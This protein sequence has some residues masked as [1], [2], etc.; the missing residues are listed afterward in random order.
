M[1]LERTTRA[2][3][4]G[5][6]Q[7]LK[8]SPLTVRQHGSTRHGLSLSDRPGSIRRH[9]LGEH[10]RSFTIASF[11]SPHAPYHVPQKFLDLY[12]RDELPLPALTPLEQENQEAI[13]LSDDQLREIK[14]GY[15]AAI[16]EVDFHVGR[17]LTTLNEL[18]RT[19]RTLI[20]FV[21]DHGEWLGDHLRL[22]KG[23]PGD[24]AVSRVPLI[25]ALPGG[26]SGHHESQI[27][28][29]VD[30]A[31][32]ILEALGVP[33]PTDMQGRSLL[34][35]LQGKPFDGTDIAVTEH[36]GWRSIRTPHHRYVISA[37]GT[38][39]LWEVSHDPSSETEVTVDRDEILA[40]HRKLFITHLLNS[41]RTLP[42]QWAY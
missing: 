32:T 35:V 26:I 21:S 31:P 38:E 8:A 6:H 19:D 34:S 33:V 36:E 24:D 7:R 4:R 1:V 15:F 3:L 40:S 9:A 28:E 2:I 22:S 30:V 18:G 10:E 39:Q 13:G 11:F 27:V 16:S 12:D 37:D 20:M 42:R 25:A 29:A 17:I 41:E 5:R 14:H 23:Y